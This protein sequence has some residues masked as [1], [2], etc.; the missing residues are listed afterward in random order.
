M[1]QLLLDA[2]SAVNATDIDNMTALHHCELLRRG[3]A[4]AKLT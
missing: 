1:V 2:K 4:L 3:G